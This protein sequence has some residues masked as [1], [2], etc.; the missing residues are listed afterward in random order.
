MHIIIL[1]VIIVCIAILISF[2]GDL[3]TY[4]TVAS[5]K[6]KPGKYVHLIAKLDPSSPIVYDPVKNPNYLSFTV[7]DSLGAGVKVVYHNAK[8]DN[9]EISERLVLKGSMQKDYFDCKEILMKCPSKYKEG[10][11]PSEQNL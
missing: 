1:I 6:N 11:L 10:D 2:M 9:L 8:P 4:D 7:M 5:A 3:S